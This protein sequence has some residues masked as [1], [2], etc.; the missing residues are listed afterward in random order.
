MSKEQRYLAGPL[1]YLVHKGQAIKKA[2]DDRRGHLQSRRHRKLRY[3]QPRFS[4][5]TKPKGWLPPSL[6]SRMAN[7]LTWVHRLMR[8]SFII[9]LSQELVK[10]DMQLMQNPEI[11]GVE[12][13]QGELAGYE[14][15]EYLL[16]KWGRTCAYCGVTGVPL[17][18]EHILCRAHGGTHRVSNLTL[19]CKPCNDK[20]GTQRIEDF[21]KRDADRLKRILAQTKAPL[22]D[23]ATMNATRWELYR[24]LQAL[25]LPVETGT[26]GR[27]KWNR[28]RRGLPKTH[29]LD[30]ACVGASTPEYLLGERVVPL[31]ILATGRQSRQ[32]CR[33][34]KY[35]F[36][37]TSA[38][39][40]R[41]SRGFQ[42]GD[43]VKA[44][45]TTG[46]K[47]GAY[48]GRVAV[49]ASGSFNITVKE[50]KTVQGISHRF[51]TPLQRNDGYNY[52]KGEAAFPPAP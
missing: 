33:M 10:F 35:G 22:R 51:C 8:Y 31:H 5:R 40:R 27:T 25:G 50:G 23:A 1:P 30:A 17:E 15:R 43:I 6:E 47:C 9:A 48:L 16:E 52:T 37:R 2:L 13:Q 49:R 36:P 41:I 7:T 3:R 12:Y 42:T 34:D 20:K 24:R 32:M 45:V 39:E 4:N 11:T 21:L 19:A 44:R 14:V 28:T 29:W 38:K 26:G 46:K 18:I